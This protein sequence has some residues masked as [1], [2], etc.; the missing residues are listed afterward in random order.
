MT[1][2]QDW[3]LYGANGYTGELIAREAVKQ[4][5]Q[6]ILAGRNKVAIKS[7]AN[8]LNL[9]YRIFDLDSP[10]S[11]I[12]NIK[13]LHTLL[14]CAGPF[15][16]TSPSLVAGCL[17]VQTN[18]LDIT[19][20]ISIFE[21]IRG[22][23]ASA[24]EDQVVLLPGV[25]FDVV[26]TDCLSLMLKNKL[27]DAT[28]LTLAFY[29]QGQSSTGTRI[30][31]IESFKTGGKI[32]KEGKL[33]SVAFGSKTCKFSFTEIG[34]L[35][36]I[37]IPWGDV[38]TAYYTTNIPNIEVYMCASPKVIKNLKRLRRIKPI[39][40]SRLFQHYLKNRT[41]KNHKNPS[42]EARIKSKS[43]IWGEVRNQSGDRIKGELILPN[44]YD[45]TVSTA[46]A[47]LNLILLDKVKPGIYSPATAFG[48]KYILSLPNV[49]LK[50]E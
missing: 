49:K 34:T 46:L 37:R 30:T 10:E 14:N 19:G 50:L 28:K 1:D 2:T 4:N 48:E 40:A 38:S 27:P 22:Y 15:S 26:P 3:M 8:E 11:I 31:A 17:D 35:T 20:E 23:Y 9:Q 36:G 29:S 16:A 5:L 18:Y 47:A 6:P 7:L 39:L 42:E 41:Y 43:Y 32:R 13:D 24:I 25:G 21:L 12:P 44:A 45:L 33:K